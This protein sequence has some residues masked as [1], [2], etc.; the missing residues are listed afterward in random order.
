MHDLQR[1]KEDSESPGDMGLG[2]ASE[3]H[4]KIQVLTQFHYL[5]VRGLGYKEV[6]GTHSRLLMDSAGVQNA[7]LPPRY[8]SDPV[9]C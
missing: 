3:S 8:A 9:S 1:A 7:S 4:S 6:E 2:G 5:Q